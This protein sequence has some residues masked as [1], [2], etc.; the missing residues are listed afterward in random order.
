MP[1]RNFTGDS[2]YAPLRRQHGGGGLQ[3]HLY[4]TSLETRTPPSSLLCTTPPVRYLLP[5]LHLQLSAGRASTRCSANVWM[6]RDV[7]D[8]SAASRTVVLCS[9]FFDLHCST[10]LP[11]LYPNKL[12]L[13]IS[14]PSH[15]LCHPHIVLGKCMQHSTPMH[16]PI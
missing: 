7:R 2:A 13:Y 6:A 3:N 14:P 12:W 11:Y 1:H 5:Q 16:R 8:A 10:N 9:L 15:L 4:Q